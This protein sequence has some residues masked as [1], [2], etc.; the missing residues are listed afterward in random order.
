[1]KARLSTLGTA[2]LNLQ[3]IDQFDYV[4][5]KL[6]HRLYKHKRVAKEWYNLSLEDIDN[7]RELDHQIRIEK[8]YER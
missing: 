7:I 3:L 5:E 8:Q 6:L 1:M 2:N 4:D